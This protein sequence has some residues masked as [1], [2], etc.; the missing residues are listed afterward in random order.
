MDQYY[1][2]EGYVE[3][4]Y[5]ER[6]V[7]SGTIGFLP[8]FDENYAETGYVDQHGAEFILVAD[9]GI[10]VGVTVTIDINYI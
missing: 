8:Y 9:V 4:A 10:V 2:E 6:I 3:A 7:D 1:I 5:F